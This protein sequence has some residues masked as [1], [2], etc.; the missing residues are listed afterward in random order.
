MEPPTINCSVL[1]CSV[2]ICSTTIN[3]TK[4]VFIT[5]ATAPPGFEL[6]PF[7]GPL[8]PTHKEILVLPTTTTSK[9]ISSKL[10]LNRST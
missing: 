5:L 8:T 4:D 2:S 3:K 7:L 1:F 10:E 6:E 9:K